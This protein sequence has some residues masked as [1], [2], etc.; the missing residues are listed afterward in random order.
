MGRTNNGNFTTFEDLQKE[1]QLCSMTDA[2]LFKDKEAK[3]A[4]MEAYKFIK[5]NSLQKAGKV[6]AR[7]LESIGE[8]TEYHFTYPSDGFRKDKVFSFLAYNIFM[9]TITCPIS[10]R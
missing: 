1:M 2:K 10:D 6:R 9:Y 5:K 7:I 3:I 4:F 8:L